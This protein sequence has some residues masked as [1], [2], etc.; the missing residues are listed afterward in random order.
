MVGSGPPGPLRILGDHAVQHRQN[1]C[2]EEWPRER[3]ARV[4]LF[5][6]DYPNGSQIRACRQHG[7]P[8]CERFLCSRVDQDDIGRLCLFFARQRIALRA[9]GREAENPV[10]DLSLEFRYSERG[11]Q[12]PVFLIHLLCLYQE[13]SVKTQDSWR[14]SKEP[15]IDGLN[16]AVDQS[17]QK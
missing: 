12:M 15:A 5:V 9:S 1:P 13:P 11:Y 14:M 7:S 16:E 3:R 8:L 10:E 4:A 6:R 2:R 17:A